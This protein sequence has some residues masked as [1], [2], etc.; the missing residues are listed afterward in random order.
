MDLFVHKAFEAK[1]VDEPINDTVN[2]TAN[3]TANGK[4]NTMSRWGVILP[5][6]KAN[7]KV[8]I[9]ELA[10]LAGTSRR[11]ITRDLEKL[12]QQGKIRRIGSDKS[13]YWETLD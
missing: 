3:D 9:D 4:V 1:H 8:T 5:T 11:T 7:P 10:A 13:G 12:K 6:I 2:D